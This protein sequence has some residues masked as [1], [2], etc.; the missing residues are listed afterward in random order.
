MQLISEFQAAFQR[1]L[2]AHRFDQQPRELYEPINYIMD[3]GGKR[4]RPLLTLLGYHLFADD[5]QRALPAALAVEIFH[6]FSLVHD[7]IMDE[8]PLR[9][10]NPT[11]HQRFGTNTGILAGDLMLIYA[12]EFLT[13]TDNPAAIPAMVATLSKVAIKVCEGQQ[14]DVNFENQSQVFLSDYLD[15]I[16]KKTAVLLAGALELGA[17]AAGAPNDDRRH[18]AEFGR[19]TGIAFQIQDDYLDIFGEPDKVGKRTGNDI[20]KNKKTALYLLALE[21]ADAPGQSQLRRWYSENPEDPTQKIDVVTAMMRQLGVAERVRALR[22]QFQDDALA[23]LAA[24]RAPEERKA[25]L[26]EL[27]GRLL[28]REF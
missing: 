14:Y 8:S 1:Y 13:R 11:V 7:D 12:Y 9:R 18:L 10:G 4:I 28:E 16:E 15:M 24:V 22:D 3:L 23:H 25:R 5:Y 27:A 19:L 6:N 20:V 2:Q 21:T 26:R 17:Q